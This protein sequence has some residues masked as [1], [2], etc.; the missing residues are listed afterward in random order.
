M[1]DYPTDLD[2]IDDPYRTC[3]I[4]DT[5]YHEEFGHTCPECDIWICQNC[6]PDHTKET[7]HK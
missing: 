1:D 3:E 5:V 4:D 2:L 6:W 7:G